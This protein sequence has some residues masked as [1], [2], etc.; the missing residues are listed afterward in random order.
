MQR[1]ILGAPQPAKGRGAHAARQLC[2]AAVARIR[3]LR[4]RARR[5]R[6]L[7][8]INSQLSHVMSLFQ[9]RQGRAVDCCE[10]QLLCLSNVR[11]D[12][13]WTAGS[14]QVHL[15][16]LALPKGAEGP[17]SRSTWKPAS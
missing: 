9:L 16:S 10:C 4:Q 12:R 6:A 1:G 7:Q 5:T 2:P 13:P 15:S 3:R 8:G 11:Q 14:Y 17:P